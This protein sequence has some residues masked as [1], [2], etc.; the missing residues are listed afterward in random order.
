MTTT[1][2]EWTSNP[3]GSP[4]KTW[5]PTRGCAVVSA[6]CKHCY[7][8]RVAHRFA[9]PR[10]PYEGLTRMA[11]AGPV[12]TGEVRFAPEML[13]AP[14]KWRKPTRVFVNSMS[15]LF[16]ESLTNEE[17][18]AVFGVMAACPQHTFQILTKRPKRMREW[19]EWVART[20]HR[21]NAGRGMSEAWF[22]LCHAQRLSPESKCLSTVGDVVAQAS[23]PLPNVHLG[24]S[25]EDQDSADERI[26]VLF[27]TPAAVRFVSAEPL[28]GS[29]NLNKADVLWAGVRLADGT[30]WTGS[31][32]CVDWIIVGGESGPKARPCDIEW[33]RNIVRQCKGAGVPVFVKQL[34]ANP[35]CDVEPTGNFRTSN[36]DRQFEL[37][38]TRLTL[39]NHKG[40][41]MAEWPE[42]LRVREFP[43]ERT[44]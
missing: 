32:G 36:G 31:K 12:W 20:A 26:P 4:G 44:E 23:W 25:V 14:L 6:G 38:A 34:G 10:Q 35:V 18:A 5:N 8:M 3:D 40:G 30:R 13:A 2:I 27:D 39:R 22:G 17:I 16:H 9:G 1:T 15:D 29:V 19:F 21:A 28:L 43:A 41:D 42:D 24:V 37:K 11:K 33:V 7:A